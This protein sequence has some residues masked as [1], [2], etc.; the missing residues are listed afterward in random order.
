[1]TD[2]ANDRYERIC[3]SIDTYLTFL[4]ATYSLDDCMAILGVGCNRSGKSV[5]CR[6]LAEEFFPSLYGDQ[7]VIFYVSKVTHGNTVKTMDDGVLRVSNYKKRHLAKILTFMNTVKESGSNVKVCLIFDDMAEEDVADKTFKSFVLHARNANIIS[8]LTTHSLNMVPKN[9]RQSLPYQWFLA[10]SDPKPYTEHFYSAI[11]PTRQQ[12]K[13][14]VQRAIAWFLNFNGLVS[15]CVAPSHDHRLA[16]FSSGLV[17][18]FDA[19]FT[20]WHIAQKSP[21]FRV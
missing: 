11:T 14:N 18:D 15:Y 12:T 7:L 1:M 10:T 4:R 6:K 21:S 16:F 17:G 5:L 2:A 3:Q 19:L 9:L 20:D 13:G 8:V